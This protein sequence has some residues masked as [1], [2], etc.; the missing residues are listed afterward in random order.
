MFSFQGASGEASPNHSINIARWCRSVKCGKPPIRGI[1]FSL[2]PMRLRKRGDRVLQQPVAH[3]TLRETASRKVQV[4]VWSHVVLKVFPTG[5]SILS[6]DNGADNIC[7]CFL[8]SGCRPGS[9]VG[10]VRTGIF[11]HQLP[12]ILLPTLT[13]PHLSAGVALINPDGG[14]GPGSRAF[15]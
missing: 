9:N 4:A 14:H 13:P 2:A 11:P 3:S 10:A 1:P 8:T 12:M 15:D 6:P 7:P 5:E